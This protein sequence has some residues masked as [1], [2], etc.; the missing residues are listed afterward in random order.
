M[1]FSFQ[2]GF[3]QVQQKDIAN[4][5]CK[6]MTALNINTRPAWYSRLYGNVE[7]KVT[8]AKAIEEIFA[9]YGIKEVWGALE[10]ET[11]DKK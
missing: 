9:A 4:V 3:S 1:D 6:I 5:R 11:S 7:P 10:P 2:K 8:E